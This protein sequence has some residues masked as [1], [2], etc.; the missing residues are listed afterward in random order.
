MRIETV[1]SPDATA[2]RTYTGRVVD[3]RRLPVEGATVEFHAADGFQ[4]S[5]TTDAAGRFVLAPAVAALTDRMSIRARSRAGG[6]AIRRFGKAADANVG[7]LV[8]LHASPLRVLVMRDG[9]P[10]ADAAIVVDL[11]K[12]REPTF[13]ARTDASGQAT[14]ESVPDGI[15]WVRAQHELGKGRARAFLPEESSVDIALAPTNT[16]DVRVVAAGTGTPIAGAKLTVDERFWI[17][18]LAEADERF[19]VGDSVT[20]RELPELA[21]VTDADGRARFSNLDPA[22]SF[23]VSVVADGYARI[24]GP[25]PHSA[26]R[27]VASPSPQILEMTPSARR[28]V[29]VPVV[30]GELPVPPEGVAVALRF[31]PGADFRESRVLPTGVTMGRGEFV[32]PAWEG[33]GALVATAGDAGSAAVWIQDDSATAREATFV[34]P[35]TITVHVVDADGH[36]VAGARAG[37]YNQGNNRLGEVLTDA[38]GR[39]VLRDLLPGLVNVRVASPTDAGWGLEVGSVDVK[40]GDGSIECVLPAMVTAILQV[41]IDGR[42]A[43]PAVYRVSAGGGYALFRGSPPP[44]IV[45]EFP[46][47]GELRIA[48]EL[49]ADEFGKP[50]VIGM[51]GSG[52][53]SGRAEWVPVRG[54]VE[55]IV[56]IELVRAARLDVVVARPKSTRVKIGLE[57]LDPAKNAFVR[58]ASNVPD[59]IS[60]PNG[61]A[62]TFRFG[63]LQ[64]GV[65][66]AIDE[67]SKTQSPQVTVPEG[68]VAS[69]DF[70]IGST[71]RVTGK[72]LMP[73]GTDPMLVRVVVDGQGLARTTEWQPNETFPDGVYVAEDGAFEVQIPGDRDVVV[74]P[75]HPWLQP[76]EDGGRFATID[77]ATGVT[78]QLESGQEIVLPAPELTASTFKYDI[79]RVGVW[80]GPIVGE[81]ERWLTAP[82]VEGALH[83][84]GIEPGRAS[85]FVDV[86]YDFAPLEFIDVDVGVGTTSLPAVPFRTGGAIRV[87]ILTAEGFDPPRIYVHATRVGGAAY[88]RS[89]NSNGE[90]EVVLRGLGAGE[91]RVTASRIGEGKKP[92]DRIVPC[93][94]VNDVILD[95]DLR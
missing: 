55:S 60:V 68:G 15:V 44:R 74:R 13:T 26:P 42:P 45:D 11:G 62:D 35:R 25:P 58:A 51:K 7:T 34:R 57:M 85:F 2:R 21:A 12:Y 63:A 5:A 80:R 54:G 38:D 52:E 22:G 89:H 87:R 29:R 94:G 72:V 32:I 16:F 19:Q 6:V 64:P 36:A 61:P 18:S 47:R 59:S 10:V 4:E 88:T 31:A 66:R 93:D 46:D 53:L 39:A 79:P 56:P 50:L 86:R 49:T 78:L 81:P 82:L 40:S 20:D 91:F 65:Y 84:G 73:P 30:A 33:G 71:K 28:D 9:T 67:V 43:L 70:A 8:L 17:P 27:L 92:I 23:T 24:P 14:I 3:D 83:F 1:A 69:V 95:F 76:A 37:A 41:R 90:A 75:W 48:V 77:G